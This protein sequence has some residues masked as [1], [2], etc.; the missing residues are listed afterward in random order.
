[1]Q[2]GGGIEERLGFHGQ[3]EAVGHAADFVVQQA[4]VGG[5]QVGSACIALTHDEVDYL[6]KGS[7]L[8]GVGFLCREH[9]KRHGNV[10]I[11]A[12]QFK[13]VIGAKDSGLV[14]VVRQVLQPALVLGVV[15]VHGEVYGLD[16]FQE[17]VG[18]ADAIVEAPLVV[19]GLDGTPVAVGETLHGGIG[20]GIFGIVGAAV[21]KRA[22]DIGDI[23]VGHVSIDVGE[24]LLDIAVGFVHIIPGVLAGGLVKVQHVAGSC[25][26]ESTQYVNKLF[27]ILIPV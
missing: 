21:A 15:L 20:V 12:G 7:L 10:P 13:E 17:L 11:A 24:H 19:H 26:N 3:G 22:G 6:V 25:Q 8:N 27:H 23:L 9:G 5:R 16:G 2:R 4:H 14:R 18:A 1:M